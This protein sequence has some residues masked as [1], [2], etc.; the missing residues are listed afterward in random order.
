[1]ARGGGEI[2]RRLMELVEKF[3]KRVPLSPEKA[4]TAKS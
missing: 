3:V 4:L 2:R 1:M